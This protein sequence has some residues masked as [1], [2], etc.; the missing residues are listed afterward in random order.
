VADKLTKEN[1]T[2]KG[3]AFIRKEETGEVREYPT[4]VQLES[5]IHDPYNIWSEGNFGCDCN[6]E[7]FFENHE[8]DDRELKCGDGVRFS[9]NIKVGGEMVYQEYAE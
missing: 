7:L 3:I 8:I 1:E 4:N 9:V 6:R 5:G 2:V